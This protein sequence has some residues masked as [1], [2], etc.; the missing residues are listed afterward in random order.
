MDSRDDALQARA[1]GRPNRTPTR[2]R[3]LRSGLAVAGAGLLAGC[4]GVVGEDSTPTDRRGESL[5]LTY[6]HGG[7][8]C[9]PDPDELGTETGWVHTVAHGERDDLTF[10][11]QVAHD[12]GAEV[13]VS[14]TNAGMGDFDL[15]FSTADADSTGDGDSTRD[16]DSTGEK[17]PESSDCIHGTR[18]TGAGSLPQDYDRLRVVAGGETVLTVEKEVTMP[19]LFDVP[20]PLEL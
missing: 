12:V 10:D 20:T 11:V 8:G 9:L 2:R 7:G 1:D 6:S 19:R 3:L 4:S 18:V 17:T 15:S 16:G 5:P 14:L 13:E